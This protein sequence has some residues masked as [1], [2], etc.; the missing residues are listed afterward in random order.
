[1]SI[2]T[3]DEFTKLLFISG[4]TFCVVGLPIQL[5]RV[6]EKLITMLGDLTVTTKNFGEF[7]TQLLEDYKA[8]STLIRNVVG[9]ITNFKEKIMDPLSRVGGMM[10]KMRS[11]KETQGEDLVDE[12]MQL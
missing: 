4:L 9:T 11:K 6:I 1:M 12:D 8:I 7:S 5:M 10:S 3:V 2:D